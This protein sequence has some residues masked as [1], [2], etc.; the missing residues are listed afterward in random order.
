MLFMLDHIHQVGEHFSAIATNQNIWATCK[1][2]T[3]KSSIYF[4]TQDWD[5]QYYATGGQR[6]NIHHRW[7]SSRSSSWY[8]AEHSPAFQATRTELK[9]WWDLLTNFIGK[10]TRRQ[11]NRGVAQTWMGPHCRDGA[12]FWHCAT[13]TIG[14]KP[15]PFTPTSCS[16]QRLHCI[17]FLHQICKTHSRDSILKTNN[18]CYTPSI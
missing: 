13:S 6:V 14:E 5:W 8:L 4:Y 10:P 3:S 11:G 12:Q 7:S 18:I 1:T 15:T 9:A 2:E 17:S 16:Q